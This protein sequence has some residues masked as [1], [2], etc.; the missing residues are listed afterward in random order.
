MAKKTAGLDLALPSRDAK[1][2]AYLWL[3]H[4]LRTEILQGKLLPGTRLPA[5]RDLAAQYGLSRGTTV[6]A[7][8]QLKAE[9][10]IQGTVGSGTYV[11]KVLPDDLLKVRRNASSKQEPM[12]SNGNGRRRLSDF[13]K[14]A[15]FLKG[16]EQRR[17]QPFRANVPAMDLFPIELWA[18]LTARRVRNLSRSLLLGCD[19]IGYRPFRE[20]VA[21]YLSSSRGVVCTPDQVAI[22][23]GMQEALDLAARLFINPG[24]KVGIENPGYVGAVAAFEAAGAKITPLRVDEEG[25]CIDRRGL[26]DCRMIYVTPAHQFPLGITMSLKRRLDLIQW[27]R[28]SKAIIFEDDYDSEYRYCGK[29]VPALQGLDCSGQVVFAGSFSKVMFPAL[30]LGYLVVPPDLVEPLATVKSVATSHSSLLQQAVLCDF[31]REGHYG[32]HIRR[33]REIYSGRQQVLLTEGRKRLKGLLEISEIEAGLQTVGW[34][35]EGISGTD[36]AEA[37]ARHGVEVVPLSRY[38]RMSSYCMWSKAGFDR[39]GLQL[40]F[41]A[42]DEVQIRDGVKQLAMA[43]EEV[44]R[45][46]RQRRTAQ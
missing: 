25:V 13:A 33:M 39:E 3:Y 22:V 6:T 43:L 4:S 17:F 10:Y 42:I 7:F 15:T 21:E 31:M 18:Q 26:R 9:G 24:D 36:A 1:I 32:R 37:S 34:L 5:T 27:A 19:A 44:A 14:R 30:R 20:A 46:G 45:D 38:S 23:S 8:D 40:G 11:S 35:S 16:Y 29:P 28:E 41:A 12:Q 2:P